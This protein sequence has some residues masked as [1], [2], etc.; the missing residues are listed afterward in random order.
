MF[1]RNQT[2]FKVTASLVFSFLKISMLTST[3]RPL[4]AYTDQL[5]SLDTLIM[6]NC[7]ELWSL[8][9][10]ELPPPRRGWATRKVSRKLWS[11]LPSAPSTTSTSTLRMSISLLNS[12]ITHII[13]S[14]LNCESIFFQGLHPL[15]N[16]VCFDGGLGC[17]C[18]SAGTFWTPG[19]SSL[20]H[21]SIY[22]SSGTFLYSIYSHLYLCHSPSPITWASQAESTPL[23]FPKGSPSLSDHHQRIRLY[24]LGQGLQLL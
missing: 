7:W 11:F 24:P 17:P 10:L 8:T 1:Q 6:V 21:N 12:A 16:V 4:P 9:Q 15:F 13:I 20:F 23:V 2:C 14:C 22:N 18:H 5:L 3:L 19:L